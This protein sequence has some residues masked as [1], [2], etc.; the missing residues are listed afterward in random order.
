VPTISGKGQNSGLKMHNSTQT[1][2]QYVSNGQGSKKP[3]FFKSPTQWVFGFLLGFWVLLGCL[4]KQEK[5]GKMI[6]KLSNLK[7]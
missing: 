5:I 1:A 4:D 3:G 2:S 6:Q 7:P